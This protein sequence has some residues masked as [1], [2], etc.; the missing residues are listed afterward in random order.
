[1]PQKYQKKSSKDYSPEDL[2]AVIK[3]AKK[4]TLSSYEAAA[5]FLSS[6]C[7]QSKVK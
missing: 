7:Q 6:D 2:K 5:H 3:E 1:M 4:D